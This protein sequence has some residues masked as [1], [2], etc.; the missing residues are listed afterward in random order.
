[1]SQAFDR[2]DLQR[3]T[4]GVK[5]S[6]PHGHEDLIASVWNPSYAICRPSCTV[7]ETGRQAMYSRERGTH[8]IDP[9]DRRLQ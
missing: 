6:G 4:S 7:E 9:S 1:M 3:L 8:E 5:S 2:I